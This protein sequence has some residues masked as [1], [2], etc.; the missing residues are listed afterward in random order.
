MQPS[1]VVK[2]ETV[3]KGDRFGTFVVQDV[4]RTGETTVLLFSDA[5][6]T[7]SASY[8]PTEQLPCVTL[9]SGSNGLPIVA[10]DG[11]MRLCFAATAKP[12]F[13][14]FVTGRAVRV[15]FH[16]LRMTISPSTLDPVYTATLG[17]VTAG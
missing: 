15:T 4:T 7:M 14:A 11:T 10:T 16:A 8:A 6:A 9:E 5:P 2:P 3:A 13:A 17:G 12:R 1:R